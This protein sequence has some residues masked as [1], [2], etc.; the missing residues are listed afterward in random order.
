MTPFFREWI[1]IVDSPLWGRG[2]PPIEK[3]AGPYPHMPLSRPKVR[4][5]EFFDRQQIVTRC[6]R[7][8]DS[9]PIKA[10]S[11][12]LLLIE[13]FHFLRDPKALV[14]KRKDV[15]FRKLIFLPDKNEYESPL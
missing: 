6:P 15:F 10:I 4:S 11:D 14:S 5:G 8:G 3:L 12:R 7:N 2:A 1:S 13:G 9:V